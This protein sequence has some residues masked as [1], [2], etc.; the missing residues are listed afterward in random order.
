MERIYPNLI[1]AILVGSRAKGSY[2]PTSDWDVVAVVPDAPAPKPDL[3]WPIIME[4]LTAPDGNMV[5]IVESTPED[6][7]HPGRFMTDLRA[8]GVDL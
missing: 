4:R 8:W 5:E 6:L 2:S 1:C 3:I 7:G